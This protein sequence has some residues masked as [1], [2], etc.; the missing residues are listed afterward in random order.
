MVLTAV[1]LAVAVSRVALNEARAIP[2]LE[3]IGLQHAFVDQP[4][5]QQ[6]F[7]ALNRRRVVLDVLYNLDGLDTAIPHEIAAHMILATTQELK[8]PAAENCESK[9]V[10]G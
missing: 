8:T 9:F 2:Q 1:L 10:K 3:P 6:F 4:L 5:R 7:G